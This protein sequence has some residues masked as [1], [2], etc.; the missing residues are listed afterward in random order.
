MQKNLQYFRVGKKLI[1]NNTRPF[2]IAEAG[3]SHF[4]SLEKAFKLVDLAYNSGA[5][6]VKFQ[7]FKTDN[8]ISKK[9][10]KWHKRMLSRELKDEEI[11]KLAKY[12]KK[13]INFLCT[14]HDLPTLDFLIKK[15][16]IQAIKIGSGELMNDEY[17]KFAS[18]QVLPT[19]FST[20]MHTEEQIKKSIN[21]LKSGVLKKIAVLHCVTSYPTN[22]K[23]VNLNYMTTIRNYFNGPVGYSDHTFGYKAPLVAASLGASIIEKHISLDFNVKNAQDW[24]VSLNQKEFK[25]F[26]NSV[27][28]IFKIIGSKKKIISKSEKK[29]IIWAKKSLH[30]NKIIKKGS[31]IKNED[32]IMLRPGNGL[33]FSYKKKFLGKVARQDLK[34]NLVINLNHVK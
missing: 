9:F 13:K 21:I 25:E 28:D 34:K 22:Y 6:A 19:I 16:K 5:S 15:I 24:K 11:F 30:T 27:D 32:L 14:A 18:K 26:I 31:Q 7:H 23:D 10:K 17:L 33:P 29:S 12:S 20:G 8:F 2:V 3:V 4:G 1:K